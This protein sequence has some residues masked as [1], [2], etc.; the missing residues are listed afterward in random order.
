MWKER[1]FVEHQRRLIPNM[2]MFGS[3]VL[4]SAGTAILDKINLAGRV[5]FEAWSLLKKIIGLIIF[6]I[7]SFAVL[8][9]T[10]FILTPVGIRLVT[11]EGGIWTKIRMQMITER[12]ESMANAGGNFELVIPA[13]GYTYWLIGAGL[14]L[15]FILFLGWVLLKK[16]DSVNGNQVINE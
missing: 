10:A 4:A 13:I 8:S 6:G 14:T 16:N 15:F 3:I 12:A 11:G 7:F 5:N 1:S 2:I 9:F